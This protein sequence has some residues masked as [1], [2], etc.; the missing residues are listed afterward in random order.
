MQLRKLHSTIDRVKQILDGKM[1]DLI[2]EQ[3]DKNRALRFEFKK[4]E[5]EDLIK[6]SLL[7]ILIAELTG[8][9]GPFEGTNL[10]IPSSLTIT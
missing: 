3:R 8:S 1:D 6:Q 10:G 4:D 5:Y 2:S 7:R 9:G